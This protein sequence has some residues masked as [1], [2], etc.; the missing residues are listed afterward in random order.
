MAQWPSD[1]VEST[2]CP[3][4]QGRARGSLP[5]RS[6]PRS[7]GR[8]VSEMSKSLENCVGGRPVGSRESENIIPL[9]SVNFHLSLKNAPKNGE[10]SLAESGLRARFQPPPLLHRVLTTGSRS[11][12]PGD[13]HRLTPH[14]QSRK[15]EVSSSCALFPLSGPETLTF[16]YALRKASPWVS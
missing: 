12:T 3:G 1:C 15:S 2:L 8:D 6:Q 5:A 4:V 9:P 11:G 10:N 16:K 14:S 13:V 7:H